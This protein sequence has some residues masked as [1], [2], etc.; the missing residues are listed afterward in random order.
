VRAASLVRAGSAAAWQFSRLDRRCS[1]VDFL[2][3][4]F[5][6]EK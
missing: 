1:R 6:L 2:M 3:G 5:S 4:I